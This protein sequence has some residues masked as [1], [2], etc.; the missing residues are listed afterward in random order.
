MSLSDLLTRLANRE[1]PRTEADVQADVRGFLL[2]AP[3]QL[4]EGDIQN[5]L[6]ESQLGDR[7]RIDVEVGSTVLEVKRDLRRGRTREEAIIQLAGYVEA[8]A[9][10]TGRRYAGVLTDGAEWDC[11]N[12]VEGEL[13]KVS[14]ISVSDTRADVEKLTVWLEGV[15]ATAKGVSPTPTEIKAR[16]GAGSSAHQL[17]RATLALLYEKSRNLPTVKLKK[18]LWSRLLTSALGTQFQDNDELFIEHTLLVNSAEIIAHAVLGFTVDTINPNSLLT[19]GK[20]DE[21]GIYGVVESDFFS[22]VLEVDGGPSF[23]RT[24]ARR[25]AR[26]DWSSVDQ[27]VLK[28]LYESVIGT[29][30]RKRLGEYYTPDW[31][32]ERIVDEVLISPLTMR[33][34]DP[35]CGS[36]TFLFHAVRKYIAEAEQQGISLA[37]TLHGVTKNVV[38]MD[39]H[40][41]AVTLARVTYLLAIGKSRLMD[42]GR[43]TIQIPVYLGDSIQW[44]QQVD[45]WTAGNLVV[46]TD[47]S[48]ELFSSELRFPD[49]LLENAALFDQLVGELSTKAAHRKKGSKPPSLSSTFQRLAIPSA[50][51]PTV[52][53]TFATMCRLHDEDRDH[54]WAYYIRNLARPMWLAREPNRVDALIGNP[55]WLAYRHMTADMQSTFREM[56][57]ARGLWQGAEIATQQD[58]SGLFVARA[59]QLYL[60]N[61]GVFGFVMPNAVV[62]REHYAGFRTGYYDERNE[63]LQ[64][65]FSTPWDLRRIRPHIFPRG[66]AVV[67][68]NRSSAA[69][70]MGDAVLQWSGQIEKGASSWRDAASLLATTPGKVSRVSSK[71]SSSY[72]E[73]FNNGATI[74]P[75]LLFLVREQRENPLGLPAGRMRVESARSS[76]E[77]A[78]WK[79]IESLS[80]VVETEFV[81][82]VMLSDCLLPFR[83]TAPATAVLP[84]EGSKL[85]G[86]EENEVE[87]YPGLASWWHQASKCWEGNRSNDRLSLRDRLDYMSNLSKQL[88][89]PDT[90]VIYNKSGMHVVAAKLRDRRAV[91]E[92]GLYWA[93]TSTEDEADYLCAI[94]NAPVVT[95][96]ARPFMSYGKDE[97]DIAKHIW[98]LPIPEFNRDDASHVALAKLAREAQGVAEQTQVDPQLHFATNRRRLREALEQSPAMQQ[99]NEIVF[100]LLS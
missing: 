65:S 31:L 81:R 89:I 20:F 23:I 78:P 51:Q 53:S 57:Q 9:E 76:N 2:E 85:L 4:E 25:L 61:D 80:A 62:D 60:K 100:E 24:L 77:K 71:D 58:L 79:K 55:P 26:F 45:L 33:A 32:A 30:T 19:G 56:C 64:L 94:L 97:R 74:F 40:P 91:I 92:N 15:L 17:D 75:R 35:A 69:S 66:S 36:G 27:D 82:P 68:G 6:L 50:H 90:R 44:R 54:I 87:V 88:P 95:D 52:E 22:W 12:L 8:R 73:R 63:Q 18:E 47:D 86:A 99:I 34:L 37:E 46:R 13:H 84:L 41:V 16:L 3:F 43:S 93:A 83:V 67:F 5:V 7:R 28:V 42:A 72:R 10:Q 48:R 14:S 1:G 38:G 59:V 98:Q 39:L 49:A 11:Y 96:M 21:S 70:A 29:E